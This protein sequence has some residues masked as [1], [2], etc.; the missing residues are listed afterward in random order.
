[1]E[2][3]HAKRPRVSILILEE[4]K[5]GFEAPSLI[6]QS[7]E[8]LLEHSWMSRLIPIPIKVVNESGRWW[9]KPC[10]TPLMESMRGWP[11]WLADNLELLC[12]WVFCKSH[13]IL[14]LHLIEE[15]TCSLIEEEG[16]TNL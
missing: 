6:Q 9:L 15:N 5:H 8:H 11:W 1:M 7:H 14:I 16:N 12:K 2:K 10:F 13:T 4:R 3:S